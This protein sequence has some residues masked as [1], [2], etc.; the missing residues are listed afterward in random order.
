MT[1]F[2]ASFSRTAER[3]TSTHIGAMVRW[4]AIGTL[5]ALAAAA[6]SVPRPAW[7][8]PADTA[9]PD[10]PAAASAPNRL[11]VGTRV[12]FDPRRGTV[13]DAIGFLLEPVHY[14]LTM[15]TVDPL[16]SSAV[17]RRPVPAIAAHAGVM[18]IES[19]LLLLIGDENRLV[20]DH[21]NRLIAIE[22]LPAGSSTATP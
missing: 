14:H 16:I 19:A 22:R 5:A 4:C 3:R 18:S 15:R 2:F 11:K 12:D 10:A 13:G 1:E 17:L 20:V 6:A 8:L 21:A 7:A 9:S